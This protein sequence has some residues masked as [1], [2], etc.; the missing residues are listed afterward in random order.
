MIH[1][2]KKQLVYINQPASKYDSVKMTDGSYS[3]EYH[4]KRGPRW[5]LKKSKL[6][7]KLNSLSDGYQQYT[8]QFVEKVMNRHYLYWCSPKKVVACK[9]EAKK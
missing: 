5:P 8:L 9:G 7:V 4:T 2:C 1:I 6:Y 3:K